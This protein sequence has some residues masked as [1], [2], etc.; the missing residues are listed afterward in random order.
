MKPFFKG[1]RC[2]LIVASTLTAALLRLDPMFDPL[3]NDPRFQ[4]SARKSS[5]EYAPLLGRTR[6]LK[7]CTRLRGDHCET[8]LSVAGLHGALPAERTGQQKRGQI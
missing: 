4:N 8:F 2:A 6:A 1:D 3:W 7:P 5:T